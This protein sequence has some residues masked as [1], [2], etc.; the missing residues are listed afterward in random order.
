MKWNRFGVVSSLKHKLHKTLSKHLATV[1]KSF[2]TAQRSGDYKTTLTGEK[3]YFSPHSALTL[4]NTENPARMHFRCHG[5]SPLIHG[6]HSRAHAL[7]FILPSIFC[8]GQWF[9]FVATPRFLQAH[10]HTSAVGS[11][12]TAPSISIVPTICLVL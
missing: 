7:T 10:F 9:R 3:S 5:A 6:C 1:D 8:S 4:T 11:T 2:S 12:F